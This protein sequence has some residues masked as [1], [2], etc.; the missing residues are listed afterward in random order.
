MRLVQA[1]SW[2]HKWLALIIGVQVLFWVASGLFF[3]VFPI[4]E[5]R[6]EH[7]IAQVETAPL[8]SAALA[9]AAVLAARLPQ[10]PLRLVYERDALGRAV[11]VAE[12]GEGRPILMDAADGRVLSPLNA[13]AATEIARAHVSAAPA[14]REV[15]E[16][17]SG[18]PEYR[19]ALPAWRVTY[20]DGLAVYVAADTGR[21]AA[22][23]SDLWRVYDT[24]WALHIMD[25]RDHENFSTW[26]LIAASAYS[27]ILVFTGIILIPYRLGW[28]R[29]RRAS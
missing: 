27:L 26:W 9:P 18:T 15:R 10:P 16:V 20:E 13:D 17:T 29:G 1:A 3:A 19:G 14:I 2:L 21:V 23:R 25:W 24:L 6:S 7:R 22:R 28:I 5:V 11:A 4:E 8:D 12:F